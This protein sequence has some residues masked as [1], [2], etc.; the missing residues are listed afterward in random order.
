[1]STLVSLPKQKNPTRNTPQKTFDRLK[2]KITQLQKLHAELKKYLNEVLNLYRDILLPEKN[3][4]SPV[5]QDLIKHLYPYF[6]GK[7]QLSQKKHNVLKD[8]VLDIFHE[9]FTF[10]PYREVD[11]E[12]RKI[13][14]ELNGASFEENMKAELGQIKSDF[15]EMF[16]EFGV[17]VDL[18]DIH[19]LDDEMD[20]MRKIAES[21]AKAKAEHEEK[22]QIRKKSKRELAK[23]QK[24]K[25]LELLQEKGIKNIYKQLAK[26]LH[27]DLELC[28]EKKREREELMK[29]VTEAYENE[30][31]C[32]LL[33]LEMT[34]LSK[35]EDSKTPQ[36][37][38]QLK[39]FNSLLKDQIEEI[40]FAIEMEMNNPRYFF[41]SQYL[42]ENLYQA[43]YMIKKESEHLSS[44]RKL[45]E[46][47]IRG[48]RGNHPMSTINNIINQHAFSD[49]LPF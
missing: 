10:I 48:L 46:E 8:F 27:P 28:P 34:W 32:T 45:A 43:P 18:D 36:T 4:M 23:E 33:Q 7:G 41:I 22:E 19:H 38:E 2:K 42:E 13:Y 20:I 26:A 25:D 1:M 47:W 6:K 16:Q 5:I 37:D 29:K 12:Y 31:L 49:S 15:Q 9:L 40:K 44:N 35:S 11:P 24:E 30:D 39:I 14:E 17:H 21:M 3:A